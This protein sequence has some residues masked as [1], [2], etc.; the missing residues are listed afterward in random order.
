M[1]HNLTRA[2][3]QVI[4]GIIEIGIEDAG[5]AQS[6][7]DDTSVA[8]WLAD[9]RRLAD[10][11]RLMRIDPTWTCAICSEGVDAE[12]ENGWIVRICGD[13][14]DDDKKEAIVTEDA[15]AAEPLQVAD[16]QEKPKERGQ[17]AADGHIFHEG[18]LRQ[19]LLKKNSCPVCRNTPIVPLH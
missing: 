14:T 8:W 4:V 17:S 10:T 13:T 16:K 6:G 9:D 7:L 18:C 3:Q 1:V 12:G 2:T 5:E 11:E 15:M 19:W